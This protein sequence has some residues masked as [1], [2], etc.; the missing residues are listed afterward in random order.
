MDL[1]IRSGYRA[2]CTPV[3]CGCIRA[4]QPL[5]MRC[6]AKAKPR[7]KLKCRFQGMVWNSR[8]CLICVSSADDL[9]NGTT[10]G[11][12]CCRTPVVTRVVIQCSNLPENKTKPQGNIIWI[13][14]I[15]KTCWTLPQRS[16]NPYSNM[17]M[18]LLNRCLWER[19]GD[20]RAESLEWVRSHC[21][22]KTIND[23]QTIS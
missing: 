15:F 17:L 5:Q 4:T 8:E 7:I 19:G 3:W 22:T 23:L 14:G 21:P 10:H 20:G 2:C 6:F 12:L 9:S 16:R 1:T 11:S 13:D 18:V